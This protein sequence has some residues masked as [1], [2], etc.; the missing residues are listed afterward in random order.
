MCEWTVLL[1]LSRERASFFDLWLLLK[2]SLGLNGAQQCISP[3]QC[4][5]VCLWRLR[6]MAGH[7]LSSTLFLCSPCIYLTLTA[8]VGQACVWSWTAG[9]SSAT[10]E[11]PGPSSTGWREISSW[12]SWRDTYERVKSGTAL[13]QLRAINGGPM[14]VHELKNRAALYNTH[15]QPTE[16][17]HEDLWAHRDL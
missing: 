5:C 1:M 9:L 17:Q 10:A 8:C 6:V 3:L 7:V 12:R 13:L 2:E 4:L 16:E 14:S 11:I 15:S